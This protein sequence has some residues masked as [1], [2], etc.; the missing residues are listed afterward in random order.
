MDSF[1]YCSGNP[2]TPI[3]HMSH[4]TGGKQID[5]TLGIPVTRQVYVKSSQ[6]MRPAGLPGSNVGE[7]G[8]GECSSRT[9][10]TTSTPPF[11]LQTKNP[12]GRRAQL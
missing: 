8:Y 10:G 5:G 1:D 3:V 12:R 2:F 7:T 9:S 4:L 11:A 6:G